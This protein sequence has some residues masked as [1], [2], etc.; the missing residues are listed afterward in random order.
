MNP[1]WQVIYY[2]SPSGDN[3]VKEFL[4][5]HL[6][7]KLKVFRIF[8]H[9]KEFGLQLVIPHIKKLSGIPLWEIRILGRDN[10]RIFYAALQNQQILLL[11]GFIK[12]TNKTPK[13]EIDLSLVRLNEYMRH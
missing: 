1:K 7:V 2:I 5:D 4:D 12:K 6:S 11:H 9:I 3:P 10:A 13:K 8:A